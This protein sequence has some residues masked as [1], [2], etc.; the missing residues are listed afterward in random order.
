MKKLREYTV[1][2][3]V[4]NFD[5]LRK[6]LSSRE[7]EKRKGPYPYYGAACVFDYVDDYLFDGDYI[8]LGEDGTVINEDGT[9]VLQRI[10]GKTWVNNHAH[11]LRNSKIID[12]DYLYYAL[13]NSNF[14]SAVTGAVQ[15]KISQAN[16]NSVKILI[17]VEKEEQKKIARVLKMLDDKIEANTQINNNLEEQL[18]ALFIKMFGEK[19]DNLSDSSIKLGDLITSIDNR[20]K[21]PPLVDELTEYPIIDVKALSG[22]S[23]IIDYSNCTK[24]VA[25]TTYE[26]WFRSGHP[27]Q[28]DILIST[29]GSLASMKL[30]L[31]NKGCIAQNVVGFRSKSVS[32]LYL[33]QYLNHIKADLLA[34]DIGSVQPSIK[35]T[36]IIKHLVFV[37]CRS[38]LDE[39]DSMARSV[40]ESIFVNSNEIQK[41]TSIRDALLPRLMSGELDV[42]DVEI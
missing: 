2:E 17:H 23:R 26:T 14:T 30:F 34:Y 40:T 5:R 39:Y 35:V 27:Q 15:P 32:P 29:V 28:Y 8:L 3:L 37:P 36:H 31:G 21:T 6:P 38:A 16:M 11:V 22:D 7:R 9:P 10:S 19:I 42:S 41:L 4:M 20:G 1:G 33:Y 24:F 25:R 12:F 13:K 18:K